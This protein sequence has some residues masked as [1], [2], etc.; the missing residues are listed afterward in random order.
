M[1]RNKEVPLKIELFSDGEDDQFS[2]RSK[3]EILSILGDIAKDHSRAALYYDEGSCFIPSMVLAVS[4]QGLWLDVGPMESENQRLL[5]SG[6]IIFIS[7]RHQVKIQFVANRIENALFEDCAAF[8]LPL[9]ESLLRI[10]RREYF[11]LTTPVSNPLRCIIPFS[12]PAAVIEQVFKI[13]KREVTIMDISGGGVALVCA[14]HE[15]EL[16]PGK[17]YTDCLI[18]LPGI[19]AINTSVKVKNFFEITLRNGQISKRAGCEFIH[20]NGES[21]TLLQRYI[22]QLQSELLV[23]G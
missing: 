5:R 20:L 11:R 15:T 12:A 3:R 18:T 23:R 2:V 16:Q 10:Q 19:G 21:T 6:K 9:P 7:S 1:T 17:I 8:F 13:L 22:T 4:D 14:A